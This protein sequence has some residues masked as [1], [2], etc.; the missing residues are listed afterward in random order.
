MLEI[1]IFQSTEAFGPDRAG[2]LKIV[3][4]RKPKRA[5]P[6]VM[7]PVDGRKGSKTATHGQIFIRGRTF[8][9]EYSIDTN[10]LTVKEAS[11]GLE[12]FRP[13]GFEGVPRKSQ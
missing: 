4:V 5:S 10:T 9:I 6:H 3:D 8:S 13:L 11:K 2:L 1:T 12:S 7:H